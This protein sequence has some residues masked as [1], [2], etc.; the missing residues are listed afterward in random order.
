VATDVAVG[1][2]VIVPGGKGDGLGVAVA[3]ARKVGTVVTMGERVSV[4]VTSGTRVG[5]AKPVGVAV[6]VGCGVGRGDRTRHRK[7]K[8]AKPKQYMHNVLTMISASNRT[9][10]FWC[11]S[12]RSYRWNSFLTSCP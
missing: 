11:L 4:A 1:V 8:L 3:V 12:R 6:K 7:I 10:I 2:T 5:G 9:S